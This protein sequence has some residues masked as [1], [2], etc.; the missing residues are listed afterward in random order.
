MSQTNHIPT[1]DELGAALIGVAFLL[2]ALGSPAPWLMG[3]FAGL[4][5][6]MLWKAYQ[7]KPGEKRT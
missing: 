3:G 6:V 7:R 4:G 5:A 2:L 1:A